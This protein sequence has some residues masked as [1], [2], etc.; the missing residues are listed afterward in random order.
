MGLWLRKPPFRNSSLNHQHPLAWGLTVAALFNEGQG[1]TVYNHAWR[2][3]NKETSYA[4]CT[5]ILPSSFRNENWNVGSGLTWTQTGLRFK[6]LAYIRWLTNTNALFGNAPGLSLIYWI[7]TPVT[8]THTI[9]ISNAQSNSENL[10]PPQ[11]GLPVGY[12]SFELG[13][14]FNWPTNWM[15]PSMNLNSGWHQIGVVV[16][17]TGQ[18]RLFCDGLVASVSQ[19][20]NPADN[21]VMAPQGFMVGDAS[22]DGA[23]NYE[24]GTAYEWRCRP[25]PDWAFM[26]LYRNPFPFFYQTG[27]CN[28]LW[29]TAAPNLAYLGAFNIIGV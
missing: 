21:K 6:Y 1:T 26:S 23:A 9:Y 29:E 18:V 20:I 4:S 3:F 25:L 12:S 17:R 22:S 10:A 8:A 28:P 11:T 14:S 5:N 2:S 13:G 15:A 27:S 16:R 7:N 19:G 24:V